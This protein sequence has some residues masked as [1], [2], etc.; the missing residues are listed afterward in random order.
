MNL[1]PLKKTLTS[2]S[3]RAWLERFVINL[4]FCALVLRVIE[5]LR[6]FRLKERL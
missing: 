1:S 5:V 4:S 3:E 2:L 6:V